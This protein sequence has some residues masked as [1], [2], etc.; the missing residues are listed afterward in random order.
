MPYMNLVNRKNYYYLSHSFRAKGRVVYR[1]K[2]IGKEI[3]SDIEA[4]KDKFLR[5]CM[6]EELF[7]KL[8]KIKN[9]FQKEWRHYPESIKKEILIDFS[10]EFTYNTNAIEGSTITLEDTENI[11]RR[12]IAPNKPLGDVQETINHSKVFFNVLNEK[13]E[14]SAKKLLQW[15]KEI[16]CDSKP[17]IAGMFR[18]YLV[19]VGN[20]IAPDWQ[21]LEKLIKEFFLWY[22]KNKKI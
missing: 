18:D 6:G 3:P 15:H 10:I 11:I 9:N 7:K 20:Y 16:F 22:S 21:D 12:K 4:I 19:K 8:S 14:L 2:Y 1:E 17:D 5:E 13:E